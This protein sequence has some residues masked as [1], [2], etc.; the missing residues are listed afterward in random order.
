MTFYDHV[1]F[2]HVTFYHVM[3]YDHVTFI[4]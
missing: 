1:T 4:I 2:Y 3:F